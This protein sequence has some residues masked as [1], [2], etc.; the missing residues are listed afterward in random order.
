M[1]DAD[2]SEHHNLLDEV[3]WQK[4]IDKLAKQPHSAALISPSCS[5]FG[6]RR[7]GDGGPEPLRAASGRE[8][9]GFRALRPEDK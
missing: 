6:C 2:N 7:C 1:L 4:I 9:Y 5:T 3:V 8:L